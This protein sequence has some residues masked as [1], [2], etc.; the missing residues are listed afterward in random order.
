MIKLNTISVLVAL[1]ALLSL[2]FASSLANAADLPDYMDVIVGTEAPVNKSQVAEQNV[3]FLDTAM[4]DIYE[5]ALQK[6]QKNFLAQHSVILGLFSN[7]GGQLTLY[8]PGKE[9]LQA[10]PVPIRYQILKSV[11]HSSLAI[12]EL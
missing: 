4:M 10:P 3:L 6:F 2:G 12:F 9:P 11:S 5:D 8:R 7:G 1:A